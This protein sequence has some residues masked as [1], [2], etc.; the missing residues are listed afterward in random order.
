MLGSYLAYSSTPKD[1]GDIFSETSIALQLSTRSFI[2]ED[3]TLHN[4]RCENLKSCVVAKSITE[5]GV[6]V[7]QD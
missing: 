4:F 7:E 6:S 5:L 3:R 1:G 2:Q